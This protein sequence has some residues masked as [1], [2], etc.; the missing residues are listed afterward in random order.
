MDREQ[1]L[2]AARAEAAIRQGHADLVFFGRPFI[3][4]SELVRNA[5][6][7]DAGAEGFTDYPPLAQDRLP[8]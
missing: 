6:I 5:L 4:N 7:F 3:A 2:D 8:A 1:R